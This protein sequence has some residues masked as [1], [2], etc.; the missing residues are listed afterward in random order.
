MHVSEFS[1]FLGVTQLS[2]NQ[3]AAAAVAA[4]I[5]GTTE[6]VVATA[7]KPRAETAPRRAETTDSGTSA[8]GTAHRPAGEITSALLPWVAV[9]TI[10][11]SVA[12][13]HYRLLLLCE[14]IK[15]NFA[16]VSDFAKQILLTVDSRQPRACSCLEREARSTGSLGKALEQARAGWSN[17]ASS[18]QDPQAGFG[19]FR[20]LSMR[21]HFGQICPVACS[22]SWHRKW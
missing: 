4:T 3:A 5:A 18:D 10:E 8:A 17:A 19:L 20:I 21:T 15:I 16:A 13:R 11:F 14:S 1:A 2:L 9:R 22:F 7:M 12:M 6:A